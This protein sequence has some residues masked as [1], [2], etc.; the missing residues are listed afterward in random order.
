MLIPFFP[1]TTVRQVITGEKQ[2]VY[3][4]RMLEDFDNRAPSLLTNYVSEKEAYPT[5]E[6]WPSGLRRRS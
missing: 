4:D 5:A 1:M 3:P 2:D 6:G